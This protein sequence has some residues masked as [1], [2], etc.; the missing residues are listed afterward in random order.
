[1]VALGTVT[2]K[3]KAAIE[4][5][6]GPRARQL[7]EDACHE[8]MKWGFGERRRAPAANRLPTPR[9]ADSHHRTVSD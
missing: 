9:L 2:A 6:T 1:M 8:V 7:A 5:E 4:G 3:I